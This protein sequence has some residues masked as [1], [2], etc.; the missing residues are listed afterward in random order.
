M[1]AKA[2]SLLVATDELYDIN[3][4]KKV[5]IPNVCRQFGVEYI[6]TFDMLRELAVKFGLRKEKLS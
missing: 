5:K 1:R 6:N 2:E 4:R 3:I